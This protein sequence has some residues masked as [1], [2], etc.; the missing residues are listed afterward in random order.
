MRLLDAP[1]QAPR[2]SLLSPEVM[3][4]IQSGGPRVATA[5]A[6]PSAPQRGQPGLLTYLLGGSEGLD[7]ERAR[8]QAELL[9]VFC[10]Q[11]AFES[12]IAAAFA[13]SSRDRRP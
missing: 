1:G 3:N 2:Y 8:R 12:E 11:A 6:A 5:P 9:P 4:L 7:A 10:A 13:A